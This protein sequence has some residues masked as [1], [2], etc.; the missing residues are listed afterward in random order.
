MTF[1][2]SALPPSSEQIGRAISH[3]PES[4]VRYNFPIFTKLEILLLTRGERGYSFIKM[5]EIFIRKL[6]KNRKTILKFC[7]VT[8][9][10]NALKEVAVL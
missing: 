3:T 6:D 8:V 4:T 9:V 7:F 1:R 5:M 2:P 10:Q